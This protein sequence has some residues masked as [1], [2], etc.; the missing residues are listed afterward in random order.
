MMLG[1][2]EITEDMSLPVPV[3]WYRAQPLEENAPVLLY[4]YG[5]TFAMNPGPSHAKIAQAL[6]EEIKG[7]V[8]LPEY[9]LAPEKPFPLAI[10]DIVSVYRCLLLN[11]TA[12]NRIVMMG[13]TA[14][15]GIA[16]A[17]LLSLRAQGDVLPAGTVMLFPWV[18]LTMSGGSYVDYIRHDGRV[19]D[20]ELLSTFLGDY[21]QGVDPRDSLAS[22]ALADL[23]QMPPF[24]VHANVNDVLVD[25]ARLLVDRARQAQVPANLHFWDDVPA[26]LQRDAPFTTQMSMVI[27]SIGK[28]SCLQ[29]GRHA[30]PAKEDRDALQDEYLAIMKN[31]IQP[32]M[33]KR[34]D[35]MFAWSKDHGPDWVWTFIEK[36][37][38]HGALA[39]QEHIER[40][41]L[42]SLF[43][44]SLQPTLL[45][46]AS[47]YVVHTN[48]AALNYLEN[49]PYLRRR[50]GRLVG[51]SSEV[52]LVLNEVLKE[53][54]RPAHA[55]E[56]ENTASLGRIEVADQRALFLRCHRLD[57][58]G[59]N[60]VA[61]PV[62][63]L[64]LMEESDQDV[65]IDK[66]CLV[67]W[68]GLSPREAMLASAFANGTSLTDYAAQER[69]SMATVRTQ[70]AQI[71]SKLDARDQASVVR[72][73]LSVAA[74]NS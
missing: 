53:P 4:V 71:K 16:L 9:S 38:E 73:V 54:F 11:G 58:Y 44:Q 27:A 8:V 32:H 19:S 18:D 6:A 45:L 56:M 69:V 72:K 33:E 67:H 7:S 74:L 70:F 10:E 1:G 50:G 62:A 22:P 48:R 15:A 5:G 61:P 57:A 43:S 66:A 31:N 36:R 68:Y 65:L 21:L 30:Q 47:R 55:R 37:I 29:M 46:T 34:I 42:G 52:E 17:A 41:W 63:V 3:T 28:F 2:G 35:E 26:T 23:H 14:G 60:A 12:P 51:I 20:V 13:D 24:H 25:D 59:A 49:G 39:T 64:R 40:E